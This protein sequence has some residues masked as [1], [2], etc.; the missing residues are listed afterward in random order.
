MVGE[1]DRRPA[2]I[3]GTSSDRIGTPEGQSYYATLS[4]DLEATTGLPVA[5]Y[6]GAAYGTYEN[7]LRAVGGL[8]LRFPRGFSSTLIHDGKELHPTAGYRFRER[9]VVSLLW[10]ALEDFGV[11]YNVAF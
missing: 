2:L 8:R 6:V 11:S 7:D 3:L 9:H 10:V 4:K 1:T 5:P